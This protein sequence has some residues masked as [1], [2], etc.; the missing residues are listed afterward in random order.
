MDMCSGLWITTPKD[1][2]YL[3]MVIWNYAKRTAQ[4]LN[5]QVSFKMSDYYCFI[6]KST[7]GI[8]GF[9]KDPITFTTIFR[10]TTYRNL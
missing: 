9:S 10:E 1:L 6:L 3:I 8:A 5:D 2:R 4:K 7:V